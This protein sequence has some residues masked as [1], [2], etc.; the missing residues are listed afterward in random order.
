MRKVQ[1]ERPTMSRRRRLTA[2]TVATV[3]ALNLGGCGLELL[4]VV[5]TLTS[6]ASLDPSKWFSSDEEV[7]FEEGRPPQQEWAKT[8][9]DALLRIAEASHARGDYMAA[10]TFY[11]RAAAMAH[12]DPRPLVGMGLVFLDGGDAPRASAAFRAALKLDPLQRDALHGLG[13]ALII[14]KQPELAAAQFH[15]AN[16]VRP[17]SRTYNGL[18]VALDMTG[19]HDLAQAIYKQGLKLD[20]NSLSLRNN[21]GLSLAL[22]G[23]YAQAIEVLREV[24]SLPHATARERQNLALTYGLAGQEKMASRIA[25]IDL[26]EKQVAANLD[27]YGWLRQQPQATAAVMLGK[28]PVEA[29]AESTNDDLDAA[30]SKRVPLL[31]KAKA[32]LPG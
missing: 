30:L 4:G 9:S 24:A 32:A 27:Y 14:T 5:S 6:L 12:Q 11:Q 8:S 10:A 20:P 23:D 17:E 28:A 19:E 21:L 18:G 2:A 1:E 31:P 16:A 22:V 26:D 13:N 3:A 7:D 29:T 25:R 15:A